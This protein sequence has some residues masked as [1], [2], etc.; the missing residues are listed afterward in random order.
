VRLPAKIVG[1]VVALLIVAVIGWNYY[2]VSIFFNWVKAA[3]QLSLLRIYEAS[4]LFGESYRAVYPPLPILLFVATARLSS[5]IV[6]YM[7]SVSEPGL[8]DFLLVAQPYIVKVL[9]KTPIIAAAI[10]I[11]ILLRRRFGDDAAFLALIGVPT[12]MTVGM[13]QFDTILALF[14]YLAVVTLLAPTKRREYIVLTSAACLA[15]ATLTKPIAAAFLLPILMYLPSK[16]ERFMYLAAFSIIVLAA[17]APFL[18][19]EPRAFIENVLGFHLHRP[20]QYSSPWSIPALLAGY[21]QSVVDI[22]NI[23]WIPVTAAAMALVMTRYR[24]RPGNEESLLL[25]TVMLGMCL[26]IT[27]KV[28]NP[29]YFMWI[30][31]LVI[32]LSFRVL[33][34]GGLAKLYNVFSGIGI[35]W[36]AAS[37]IIP[38]IFSKPMYI[39]ETESFV[40]AKNILMSSI[41]PPLNRI[42]ENVMSAV[43]KKHV[44]HIAA[45][46]TYSHIYTAVGVTLI[47]CYLAIGIYLLLTLARRA[48]QP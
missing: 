24:P 2:D 36:P 10:V 23:L 19:T 40:S 45:A 37:V 29:D 20:P 41:S 28:V 25:S 16:R 18:A 12:L 26:L 27:I 31:P 42:L 33:K 1:A 47:G 11:A 38:A 46:A 7:H 14:L 44:L 15:I 43:G 9:L 4:V 48:C 39:Q 22:L 8:L 13:L 21:R 3:K 6:S 30:Y 32:A 34:G 5:R 17:S 35:A